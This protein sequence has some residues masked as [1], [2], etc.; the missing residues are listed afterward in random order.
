MRIPATIL[1]IV[2]AVAAPGAATPEQAGPAQSLASL[3]TRV[4]AIAAELQPSLVATRRDLHQHPELGFRETRT[5]AM[6]AD[7]LR[8]LKFDEVRTGVGKTGVVG[9]LKG[10]RPGPVVAVRADMDALPV[11]EVNDVP[12]K[13]L[14]PNVKHACGHDSH[15]AVALG[16]AE[17]MSRL[18]ADL[19]GTVVFLFQPAEEGD[20][21]GG[22]TGAR[23]VLEDWP[24][25]NPTPSVIFGLHTYPSL[26]AGQIGVISGAA[27]ASSDRF[28]VTITG[29]STHGAMPHTGIDPIPVAAQVVMGLQTI[30]ARQ[31]DAQQPT[32]ITVGTIEGGARYNIVAEKVTMVGTVRSLSQTGPATVKERMDKLLAGTTASY[33]ATYTLDYIPTAPVTF[34]DPALAAS[35]RAAL[36]GALGKDQVITVPS[37]MVA[38]DFAYYQQRIP[39]FFF[40]MG[41]GNP[42]RGITSNWHTPTFDIDEAALPVGVRAMAAVVLQALLR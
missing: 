35:S 25:A 20:P 31:M 27:M 21:D 22:P 16:V 19:P 29:K 41:V 2:V 3:R 40:F 30:P 33:G 15:V 14:V 6:V 42:E 11:Q 1:A 18:R 26:R 8:A 23:R 37:Q 10:G 32:V 12:Y 9:V 4:D 5:A 34:N 38:E 24:L 17:T 36:E 7:R 39:G 28:V 13:S